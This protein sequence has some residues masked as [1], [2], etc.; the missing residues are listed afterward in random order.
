MGTGYVTAPTVTIAPPSG[1]VI[2]S[3]TCV[4]ATA[5][6]TVSGGGITAVTIVDPG[7]GYTPGCLVGALPAD[8]NPT[9]T[10]T[11][12][13]GTPTATATLTCGAVAHIQVTSG[14]AGYTK[15]PFVYITGG[16]GTGATAD[17]RLTN[18]T[19]VGMKNITE[20]TDINFGRLNALLG[21]TPV[22]LDPLAPA[23][24]VPGIAQYIDPPSDI[25]NDG[26]VYVFRLAH[27]GVDNHAVHFHLANLQVVN[28]VDYTNTMLPPE[29]ERAGLEGNHPDGTV[30]GPYSG[31]ASEAHD[32]PLPD[33]TECPAY[34]HNDSGGF[35]TQLY[36]AGPRAGH[37]GTGTYRQH[38]DRLRLGIR[39]ALPPA[40]P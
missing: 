15:A 29:P 18:D 39:L 33:S 13:L 27:L 20:G 26:Q 5:V 10:F 14:G 4:A 34:G 23:P 22:P 2:N 35:H 30:Y 3:T 24:A 32:A 11:P 7:A 16:G 12:A 8:V 28:R 37:A 21:T 6:A 17:A 31:G 36:T 9:V 1:C 38:G 25:W 19:V 40:G